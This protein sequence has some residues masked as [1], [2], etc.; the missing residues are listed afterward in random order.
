MSY[1]DVQSGMLQRTVLQQMNATMNSF[2]Q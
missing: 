2:Y 1:R